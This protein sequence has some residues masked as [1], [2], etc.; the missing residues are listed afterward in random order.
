MKINY[1]SYQSPMTVNERATVEKHWKK[2]REK[3]WKVVE[4]SKVDENDMSKSRDIVAKNE[5]EKG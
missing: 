1:E 2:N 5:Q 4:E 3:E